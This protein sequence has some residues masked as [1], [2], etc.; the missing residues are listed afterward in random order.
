MTKKNIR[1]MGIDD[2]QFKFGD[3][4]TLIA[5]VV[6]RA[7]SYVESVLSSEVEI[8]GE[9]ATMKL[10]ELIK[11][12]KQHDQLKAVFIDGASLGGFNV[13]NI[14]NIFSE[15]GIPIITIT[16]NKPDMDSIKSALKKHF[17]DWEERF[18][19]LDQG[20]LLEIETPHKPIYIKIIG[21]S[22]DAAIKLIKLTT[23]RGVLPEPIRLAHL[24]ATGIATG[25][26]QSKA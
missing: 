14:Q 20:Q 22:K 25:E 18:K 5:A 7:P 13:F 3:K 1:V 24:I 16:R 8:D 21:I 17:D 9:D 4:K 2:A 19:I 26:S 11:K 10:I 6:I 23:V 12:S 15:I